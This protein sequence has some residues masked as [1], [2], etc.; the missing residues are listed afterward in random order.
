V[1]RAWSGRPRE[2][3]G[4][5]NLDFAFYGALI[6]WAMASGKD[7]VSL[8]KGMP[9]VKTSLGAS[10]CPQHAVARLLR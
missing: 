1:F 8:G 3:G 2:L 9:G 10:L 6:G 4:P 7:G 5:S